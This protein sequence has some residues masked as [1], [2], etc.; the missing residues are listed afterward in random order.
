MI[1][2]E[3][4]GHEPFIHSDVYVPDEFTLGSTCPKCGLYTTTTEICDPS[5]DGP[6]PIEFVCYGY[7]PNYPAEELV[8]CDA[9]WK[10]W[11]RL[12]LTIEITAVD[13]PEAQN[14]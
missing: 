10:E 7:D 2:I 1:T 3:P 8:C 9:I 6:T 5:F 4:N 14:D 11:V 13:P 12:K